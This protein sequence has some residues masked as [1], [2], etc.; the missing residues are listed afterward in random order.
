M[1]HVLVG[2]FG[3]EGSAVYVAIGGNDGSTLNTSV[4]LTDCVL[5]GNTGLCWWAFGTVCYACYRC[6]CCGCTCVY[7][8]RRPAPCFRWIKHTHLEHADI[9]TPVQ[10]DKQ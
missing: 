3:V 5:S 7:N 8:R 2:D 10:H 4:T 1:T 6:R 9:T